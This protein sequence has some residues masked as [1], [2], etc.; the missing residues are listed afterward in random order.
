MRA[1]SLAMVWLVFVATAN[2]APP[3]EVQTAV[4]VKFGTSNNRIYQLEAA[5]PQSL[6]VWKPVAPAKWG[7]G[8]TVT[9]VVPMSVGSHL[10][11]RSREYDLTNGLA[12]YFP[13]DGVAN[14][15]PPYISVGGY[16]TSRFGTPDRA[17]AQ[18]RWD[19]LHT[20][21]VTMVREF[22]VGTND[23]TIS[24]WVLSKD[25]PH[26]FG[27]I[28]GDVWLNAAPTNLLQLSLVAADSGA[29]ELYFGGTAVPIYVTQPLSW[30]YDRWYFFQL[31]RQANVFRIYRDT[32]LVGEFASAVTNNQHS[33]TIFIGPESGAVDEVRF[34]KRALSKDEIDV[35]FRLEEQ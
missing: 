9:N 7:R 31:V 4:E 33:L 35:L 10:V 30:E 14:G 8:K 16:K 17:V 34:Y 1:I 3:L 21:T 6:G 25:S 15:G 24:S 22:A 20:A 32:E 19:Y 5:S 26:V 12:Y 23:F 27:R 2:G 13:L 18:D 29:I 11:F 28:F